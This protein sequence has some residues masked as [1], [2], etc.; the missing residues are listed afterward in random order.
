MVALFNKADRAVRIMRPMA[1][2]MMTLVNFSSSDLDPCLSR[3]TM[4]AME[5]ALTKATVVAARVK[6]NVGKDGKG[7]YEV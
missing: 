1:L 3:G 5:N 4:I 2:K 7:L 6:R